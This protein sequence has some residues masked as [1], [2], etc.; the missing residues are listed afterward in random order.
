MTELVEDQ[1]C[2]AKAKVSWHVRVDMR[3]QEWKRR[4]MHWGRDGRKGRDRRLR[5]KDGIRRKRDGKEGARRAKSWNI[6]EFRSR[7]WK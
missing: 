2:R 3:G 5:Q 6:C 1:T 4:Q 7:S